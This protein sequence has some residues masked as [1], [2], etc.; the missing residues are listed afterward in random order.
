[1]IYC[2]WGIEFIQEA[3]VRNLFYCENCRQKL[4]DIHEIH[5]IEENSDR[6]FCGEK[7]ILEFYRPYMQEFESEELE[8]RTQL[9]LPAEEVSTEVLALDKYLSQA[10]D[11][12][13]EIWEF[14]SAI[15]QHFY[16]HILSFVHQDQLYYKVL[17]TTY[18]EGAPSFVFY[19]LI[20]QSSELVDLYR[21]EFQVEVSEIEV[22]DS[23]GH[24]VM[25]K[26]ES[27][28]IEGSNLS[29][30]QLSLATE[31]IE[32]IESKKSFL[33]AE[34]LIKRS[35]GDIEL[36]EF[37]SYDEYLDQTLQNPDEVYEFEDDAG[38]ILHTCIRSYQ[39]GKLPF[40][41]I[42]LTLPYQGPGSDKK[43]TLIPIL[44]F[45][46]VDKELYPKY[47]VGKRVDKNLKN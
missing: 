14:E 43:I 41:Y 30:A 20:T 9:S 44:G 15:N 32:D 3:K 34:M 26:Q 35:V 18:V 29:D 39:I 28:E 21:R 19:R 16:T 13:A 42:L 46:S 38:D 33:L 31:L 45:P 22:G 23:P 27:K 8:F 5:Y 24:S 40:F 1:V 11:H 4:H 47:A 36:E 37:P 2:I 25:H 12:P 7:C 10:L 6:G 17:I